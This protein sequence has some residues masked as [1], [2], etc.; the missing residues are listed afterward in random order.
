M[1]ATLPTNNLPLSPQAA[2][3]ELLARRSARRSLIEFACYIDPEQEK[4]YRSQHLAKAAEY[5][6]AV[7]R[8]V[9][10]D[11]AGGIGR[12]IVNWPPR[13]WKTS[14]IEKFC[15]WL[16]G[17]HPDWPIILCSYSVDLPIK[18]SRY[19]R[20]TLEQNVR[21][22]ALF[23][24]VQVRQDSRD[25]SDWQLIGAHRSSFRA[26]GIGGGI[27]GMGAK[28]IIVDDV[29]KDWASAQSEVIRESTWDWLTK[30]LYQRKE[31]HAAIVNSMTRW[32]ED[33]PTGRLIKAEKEQ[34][35]EH[36]EKICFSAIAEKNDPLGRAEGA[37]LWP[38]RFTLKELRETQIF[39]GS[40]SWDLTWQQK[41][42]KAEGFVIKREWF[43]YFPQLPSDAQWKVRWWDFALTA[44]QTTKSDPDF[45]ASVKACAHGGDLWLAKPILLRV[46][47][48]DAVTQVMATK[49]A[50]P[51]VKLGT[52]QAYADSQPVK[53][54][55]AQGFYIEKYAEEG[56]KLMRAQAWI[57]LGRLRR[58]KLIGPKEDW[59]PFMAQWLK[60]PHGAH[61]DAVDA[62]SG[63]AQMLGL[64]F[65]PGSIQ[66]Q[67]PRRAKFNY[68]KAYD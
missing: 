52:G 60:F 1:L 46:D 17:K 5:F 40:S 7:E 32:H 24:A 45:H 30:T 43:D 33:D 28:V 57:N 37:P 16:L 59:E 8:F 11:G 36:W 64:R 18:S 67:I 44:K 13:H 34:G 29:I 49:L 25:V 61:D 63:C 20:D 68:R 35:T 58:V 27:T 41:D 53:S 21:Y 14:L 48:T 10:S 12:L 2:A 15:A 39:V 54:L 3:T 19:V 23:P 55:I 38:E 4:W 9:A 66:P 51:D 65:D 6:E 47:W 62:V 26:V 22:Q 42:A 50:E 56:D 31:P